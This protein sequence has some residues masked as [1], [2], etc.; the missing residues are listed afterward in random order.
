MDTFDHSTKPEDS[1]ERQIGQAGAP[2][3][4]PDVE[5]TETFDFPL[6]RDERITL[7]PPLPPVSMLP[8]GEP[9]FEPAPEEKPA[10]VIQSRSDGAGFVAFAARTLIFGSIMLGTLYFAPY[11]LVHWRNTEAEADAEAAYARRRAEL[12]AEA[13]AAEQMLKNLDNRVH[14]TS[15]GFREVVRKVAPTVVN[16]ANFREPRLDEVKGLFFHDPELNERLIQAGVG[17][18]VI[19]R[20]G[21]IL[22]N[23]HVVKN[24]RKLRI[25]FA[26]G[27]TV[28]EGPKVVAADPITDLAVIRLSE[29]LADANACAEFT[30]SDKSVQVGDWALAIGSPLGLKQ[31][32]T[33]GV[34]SAKGRLLPMLD[35]VEL[36]QTDAAINPGN[37]GGPLFDQLGRV[38]GINVAIASDTG[39][40]QGI[41]FAIPSNVARNIFEQLAAGGEVVRGYLGV[42]LAELSARQARTLGL[43]D[44]GAVQVVQVMPGEAAAKAG[45]MHGDVIIRY[46]N[47]PL[48]R[49]QALRQL[50]QRILQTNPGTEVTIEIVRDGQHLTRTAHIGKRPALLP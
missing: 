37:S 7:L 5:P 38:V 15:L 41:G 33:Q 34:I 6:P 48:D 49:N 28:H 35:G 16:V 21:Q 31:T 19:V 17:S 50:R 46:K 3:D 32:V 27:K 42:G 14:L 20:P 26:S 23:Y 39:V 1:P 47:E 45:L 43:A 25:T 2:A 12:R 22:T 4:N 13:E 9:E 30:D 8:P 40:N 18:G 10:P 11:L 24:A 36:L 29:K 44:S